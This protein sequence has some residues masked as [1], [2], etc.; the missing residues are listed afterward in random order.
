[1]KS[2]IDDTTAIGARLR[3]LEGNTQLESKFECGTCRDTGRVEE[4]GGSPPNLWGPCPDCAAGI[5]PPGFT[6]APMPAPKKV[7]SVIDM[8]K[9]LVPPPTSP[10]RRPRPAPANWTCANCHN[11]TRTFPCE[12]CGHP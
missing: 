9:D 1:M 12:N 3:E 10:A 6:T 7:R 4:P 5:A 8:M 2:I 11:I